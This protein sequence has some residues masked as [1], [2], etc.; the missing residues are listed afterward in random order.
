MTNTH[1]H[2]E[3]VVNIPHW[4]NR[5][6]TGCASIKGMRD[7]SR[8]PRSV[9][10]QMRRPEGVS[11]RVSRGSRGKISSQDGVGNGRKGM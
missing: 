4:Q 2:E 8:D 11:P 5:E 9:R 6:E 1:I 7:P 3:E 10:R